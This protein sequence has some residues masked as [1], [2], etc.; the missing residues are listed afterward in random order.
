MKHLNKRLSLQALISSLLF[1]TMAICCLAQGDKMVT[2]SGEGNDFSVS[3][4]ADYIVDRGE[5]GVT[6]YGYGNGV[7]VEVM[8]EQVKKPK[9]RVKAQFYTRAD[10][11]RVL[12]KNYQVGDFQIARMDVQSG[13][14][15]R[16]VIRAGSTSHYYQITT[17]S[18]LGG[19]PAL[20]TLLRSLRF[21]GKML[22][23]E[24]PP[25]DAGA[26]EAG[27]LNKLSTSK[28]VIDALAQP[29]SEISKQFAAIREEPTGDFA[30]YSR[31]L[32]VLRKPRPSYT[33]GARQDGKQGVIKAKVEFLATGRIG[34]VIVDDSLDK[35]LAKN[36]AIAISKIKFV[37]A[38][39]DHRPVDTL[40]VLT[41]QFTIY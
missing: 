6:V 41:Y 13:L 1:S 15:Y 26:Q 34:A 14:G 20:E 40:R 22:S 10:E 36:V 30:G 39:K 7:S 29:N 8:T 3:V 35:G 27:I 37:P 16:I 23:G 33:D 12:G 31:G 21:E 4:P 38:T 17:A 9:E 5:N 32:I 28:E 24:T 2:L 25:T 19:V 11:K 18:E